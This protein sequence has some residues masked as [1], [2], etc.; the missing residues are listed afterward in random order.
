MPTPTRTIDETAFLFY[1]E[2]SLIRAAYRQWDAGAGL[3]GTPSAVPVGCWCA[4][5]SK[6]L[7]S[8]S[9]ALSRLPE[10]A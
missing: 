2:L 1:V 9:F 8:W 7:L 3:I 4:R 10:M 6:R 5:Q